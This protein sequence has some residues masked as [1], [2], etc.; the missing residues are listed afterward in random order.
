MGSMHT[1]LEESKNGF[2]KV[3]KFYQER[4][5]GGVGLIITGG[6][7]PNL[8]G[9]V[10]P[11]RAIMSNSQDV[12]NHQLI[13]TAVHQYDCKICMQILHAGRYAYQTKLVSPSAIRAPISPYTPTELSSNDIKQQIN[14]FINSAVLAQKAGYD[15]IEIMGSEGYLVNQFI[16]KATNHRTDQWGGS[17]E[18]RIRFPIEIIKQ[19]RRATGKNFIIIFRLSMIDLIKDGSCAQDVIKLAE[20]LEEIGVNIINMGIGWHE[21][22]VPTI[23]A[24][25][26][27]GA[28]AELSK[29][30]KQYIKIPVIVSNRINT[31]ELAEEL[32]KNK[33][34][35]MVSMARPFLADSQFI[36]KVIKNIP[37]Q[38]NTCI[39]CNQGCL[40]KIFI[41]ATATC[42]VNPLACKETEFDFSMTTKRKNLAVIGAGPAGMAFSK[43][44]AKR[45]HKVTLFEASDKIG[46]QFNLAV[47]IPGK[48]EFNETLRYFSTRLPELGVTIMLNTQV[49]KDDLNDFDEVIVATGV[50]PRIPEIEG[51]ENENVLSYTDVLTQAKKVGKKVAIIGGGG[52]AFDIALYLINQ[53]SDANSSHDSDIKNFTQE[54]GIDFTLKNAGGIS[55]KKTPP[56]EYQINILQRRFRK[57][58]ADLGRTTGWV[59]RE[60]LRNRNVK[61]S[62]GV[63]YKKIDDEGLHIIVRDKHK[64]IKVDT[65]I[66]CSGQV[67]NQ[68]LAKQI[69]DKP[70]HL[71]GGAS[72]VEGLD[73]ERA[74]LE[75]ALLAQ[76]I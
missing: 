25:V 44:A 59:I 19:I 56:S 41:R 64:L 26:P 8:S 62:V 3:S 73:A 13:T 76:S 69:T 9:I 57:P 47:H 24:S 75:A 58:G 4:A 1:N 22:R 36:N 63:R 42:L 35:D 39:A 40:D 2:Q 27:R 11:E 17:F 7:S 50:H 52:I 54:W 31:P 5:K 21:S 66:N 28:F 65:I 15:G 33:V 55:E 46:G 71:I 72:S 14:D 45:G 38:I 70:C 53:K 34:A 10:A 18:N 67:A 30:I 61:M 23:V 32:L 68:F 6:I 16:V 74:I 51:I 49:K 37:A 12:I 29:N 60:Q 43:Y 20:K 48:S